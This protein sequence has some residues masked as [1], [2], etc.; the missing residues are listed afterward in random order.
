MYQA[1]EELGLFEKAAS[2]VLSKWNLIFSEFLRF[3]D[4]LIPD[5]Q[6]THQ[7]PLAT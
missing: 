1:F 6:R 2:N 5:V 7:R 4:F 3:L